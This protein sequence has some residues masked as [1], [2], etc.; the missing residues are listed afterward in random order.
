LDVTPTHSWHYPM[1]LVMD[2]TNSKLYVGDRHVIAAVDVTWSA[3]DSFAVTELT[4][5]IAFGNRD[6]NGSYSRLYEPRFVVIDARTSISTSVM[7][8]TMPFVAWL[9]RE[10]FILPPPIALSLLKRR[11]VLPSMQLTHTS[12]PSPQT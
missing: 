1:G 3:N 11:M 8:L 12:T 5:N 4:G 9:C 7:C 10:L 6:G 2:S